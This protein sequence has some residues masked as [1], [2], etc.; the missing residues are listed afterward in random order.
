[1]RKARLILF[2][3]GFFL[4]AA[5]AQAATPPIIE[6]TS[7]GGIKAWLMTSERL[8]LV[9]MRFAF[10]GGVEQDPADKQGLATLMTSL[11]TQGAGPYDD[12]A[13][14][15]LL[16]KKSIYLDVSAGR[17]ALTGE[18]KCLRR[19]CAEGFRL[20][21]LALTKPRFDVDVFARVRD[22]QRTSIKFQIASPS[23]QGRYALFQSVFGDHPYGFRSL[24]SKTSVSGLTREDV[25]SF[26]RARL[27]K[28][29]LVVA[30][31]G[32]I[33]PAALAVALDQIFGALP[34]KAAPDLLAKPQWPKTPSSVL[35]KRGGT[36]TEILFAA[37]MPAR[38]DADWYAAEIAN[39]ILGGG[40]FASRLM[41]EVR[42][43]EGLTYGI[44]TG[45]APMDKTSLLM[46]SLAAD[47][48][49]AAQALTLTQKTWQDLYDKG[50][51]TQEVE[52]AKAYL[53]GS[54]PLAL[55]SSDAAASV[56]L[57]LQLD[58]FPPDYLRARQAAI[59]AVTLA[60]VNRVLRKWFDPARVFYAFVGEPQGLGAD[61]NKKL[62]GE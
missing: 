20:L 23:W 49:K 51:T 22:Q 21:A 15:S 1:M 17:D 28:D 25:L 38:K 45:L 13:F 9:S 33:K 42:E 7:R 59:K 56:L 8:P 3:F 26:A 41:K 32:D 29:N 36:Q 43:K 35:V 31:V 37:P 57:G 48:D 46:G 53:T 12:Q 61:E 47:N 30:V 40:S 19:H 27:A 54:L 34:E 60:D 24:G 39:Y 55:A 2:V 14:Q 52:E 16:A 62:V 6:V 4:C 18:L 10:R 44:G 50:A 58:G 11:L 5:S